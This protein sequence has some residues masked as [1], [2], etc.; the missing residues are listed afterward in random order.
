MVNKNNS[1]QTIKRNLVKGVI[2]L[3]INS[4]LRIYIKL[5]IL[6]QYCKKYYCATQSDSNGAVLPQMT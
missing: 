4:F 3:H 5:F 2:L 1:K 6:A